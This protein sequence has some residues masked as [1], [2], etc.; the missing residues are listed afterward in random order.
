MSDCI[1]TFGWAGWRWH[2][3]GFLLPHLFTHDAMNR[4]IQNVRTLGSSLFDK[5]NASR[6]LLVGAGGIGCELLKNLVMSGFKNIEVAS[7]T[8]PPSHTTNSPNK[9]P[10]SIWTRLIFPTWIVSFYSKDNMSRK[11]KHMYVSMISIDH[12]KFDIYLCIRLPKS[13]LYVSIHQSTLYRIKPISWI[14]NIAYHGFHPLMSSSMH[15][16]ISKHVV[17]SIKCASL[18]VYH[19]LR[20]VLLVILVKPMWLKR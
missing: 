8:P 7:R 2:C 12:V 5:V 19:W 18:L 4:D 10:R 6:V 9:D 13:Q 16:T 3:A 15:W 1:T 17:M 11:Q 20:Q 14:Q